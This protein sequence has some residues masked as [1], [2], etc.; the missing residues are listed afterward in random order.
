MFIYAL[1][2]KTIMLNCAFYNCFHSRRYK[3]ISL[4]QIPV[5][6]PS[7]SEFTL[8]RKQEARQGWMDAILRTRQLDADLRHQ[9]E[10]NS[11]YI[12]EIHFK[13]NCIERFPKRKS[14]ETG[15]IRTENLPKKSLDNL[16]TTSLNA[17][18][19]RK[20]PT[21]R[22]VTERVVYSSLDNLDN[23][24]KK[25]GGYPHFSGWRWHKISNTTVNEL[26]KVNV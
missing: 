9:I 22:H 10:S 25:A 21:D 13:D 11:V 2:T 3:G 8:T 5:Y 7:D 17:N 24:L 19:S 18:T 23:Y 6:R 16:G 4:F 14:L 20:E 12:C 1:K 26:K 15:S